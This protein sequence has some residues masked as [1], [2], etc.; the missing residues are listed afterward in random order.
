MKRIALIIGCVC[1]AA[2]TV[3]PPVSPTEEAPV[4]ETGSGNALPA[5]HELL[6]L[7]AETQTGSLRSRF[8]K[9]GVLEIGD[10][11]APHTLTVFTL[12]A[13]TYCKEF[14]QVVLPR[15]QELWMNAGE[16][17]VR[18]VPATLMK[19]PESPLQAKTLLCA[20]MRN[21]GLEAWNTLVA[22]ADFPGDKA[23]TACLTA[24]ET[25][26]M[27]ADLQKI[28]R[29]ENITLFPSFV[30]DG[31]LMTGLPEWTELRAWMERAMEK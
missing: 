4:V 31:E 18:L 26:A 2:C 15:L 6:S 10:A 13:C 20:G 17:N 25:D 16:L 29:Q 23:F 19:Y 21:R 22:D 27:L 9:N 7:H 28:L 12:P 3:V 5:K 24:P 1:L 14:H 8:L 11:E 30:L